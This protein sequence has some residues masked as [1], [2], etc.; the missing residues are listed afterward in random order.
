VSVIIVYIIENWLMIL[1]CN[2]SIVLIVKYQ[3][4]INKMK[5]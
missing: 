2:Y 3:N 5:F 1:I 4:D